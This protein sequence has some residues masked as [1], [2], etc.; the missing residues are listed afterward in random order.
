MAEWTDEEIDAAV[1]AHLVDAARKDHAPVQAMGAAVEA[2]RILAHHD[3]RRDA[4]AGMGPDS[5]GVLGWT[6]HP[7]RSG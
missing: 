3:Q 7:C 4:M 5:R 1:Q 6:T 2:V